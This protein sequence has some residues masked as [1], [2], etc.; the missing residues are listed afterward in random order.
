MR[1]LLFVAAAAA[2]A[3]ASHYIQPWLC[4]ER[5]N[6][7]SIAFELSQFAVNGSALNA[8][9]FEDY[10][11]GPG[12]TLVKNNLTQASPPLQASGI[13]TRVAMLSSFPY[14]SAFLAWMR[15]LFANPEPFISACIAASKT[16]PITGFNVD[17][18]PP[19]ASGDPSPTPQDALDYVAFLN[20]FADAM[21]ANGLT[22]SVDVADWSA[23]W[24]LTA[25]GL[26]RVDKVETMSTYTDDFAAFTA[27]LQAAVAVIPAEK[28]VVGLETVHASDGK[29][30][31]DA[32]L[33]ERF[34]ALA[35]L[36]IV[37]IGLWKSPIPDNWWPFLDA[38]VAR[39]KA[40]TGPQ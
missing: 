30:Y 13:Q 16:E 27:A 34:D 37:Q 14:P 19:S 35:A 2:T 3:A 4:L 1:T 9:A 6:D 10:N 36:N 29:P 25:L 21:H 7:T 32:E 26:S 20:V 24:N 38:L 39:G 11:L 28:L 5:C 33:A 18:E 8:A 40:A 23:I 12:S 22:V 31:T 15:Q 17:W